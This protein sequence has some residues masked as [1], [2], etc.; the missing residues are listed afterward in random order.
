MA[1]C[2][3]ENCVD[4]RMKVIVHADDETK[5]YMLT[6]TWC[7]GK[8]VDAERAKA[9]Q[10]RIDR[11][12]EAWCRCEEPGESVYFEVGMGVHGYTCRTCGKLLQT[13]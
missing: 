6:C 5:E 8:P 11:E 2:P 13:G 9:I 7:E 1:R 4:G 12:R 10:E 3:S